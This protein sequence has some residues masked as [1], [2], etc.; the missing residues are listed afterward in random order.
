[1]RIG[2]IVTCLT[3]KRMKKPIGRDAPPAAANAYCDRECLGYRQAP[4]PGSLWPGETEADFGYPI[5][6]D[7]TREETD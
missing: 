7:G 2:V 1:M 5:G 6:A 4:Y 3:C